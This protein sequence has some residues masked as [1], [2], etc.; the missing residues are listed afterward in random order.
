MDIYLY[1]YLCIFI[2]DEGNILAKPDDPYDF[3]YQSLRIVELIKKLY[4]N[5][6]TNSNYLFVHSGNKFKLAYVRFYICRC[7]L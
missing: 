1:V 3:L 5:P 4:K 7:V 2:R 6:F